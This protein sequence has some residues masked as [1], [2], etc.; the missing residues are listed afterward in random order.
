[1]I[2]NCIGIL[3]AFRVKADPTGLAYCYAVLCKLMAVGVRQ[4]AIVVLDKSKRERLDASCAQNVGCVGW[5][6]SHGET[7]DDALNVNFDSQGGCHLVDSC[8]ES[9]LVK[10]YV[11]LCH[12][13]DDE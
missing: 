6:G 5:L 7:G 13:V 10:A 1:M 11:C 2:R 12:F 4:L 9:E 8:F 3:G